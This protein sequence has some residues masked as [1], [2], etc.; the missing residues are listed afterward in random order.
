MKASMAT[1]RVRLTQ[2]LSTAKDRAEA[3]TLIP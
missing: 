2:E 1:D 3:G